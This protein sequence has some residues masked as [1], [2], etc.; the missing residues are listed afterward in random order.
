MNA[1]INQILLELRDDLGRLYGNRLKGIKLFGSYARKEAVD[2]SD[3]D[4]ALIL[5]DFSSAADEI[6]LFS[7]IVA[8]LCLKHHCVI[9]AIPIRERD[10]RT[11]QTPLLMNIRRESIS[12]A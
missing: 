3:I 5:E 6:S 10:W 4:I 9:S 7:P 11:R 8:S 1:P 2:G 12:V